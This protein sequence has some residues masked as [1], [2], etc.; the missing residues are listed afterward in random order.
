MAFCHK[1]GRELPPES[2]FCP[3]CGTPVAR[4]EQTSIGP[5]PG[6]GLQGTESLASVGDRIAAVLIDSIVLFVALF[7]FSIF[8]GFLGA[9]GLGV[10]PLFG[11]GS[12]VL[13]VWWLI[14]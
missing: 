6:T 2:A 11:F 3:S 13:L 12:I 9:L 10:F 14:W 8:G 5:R 1:C 7:V 4:S